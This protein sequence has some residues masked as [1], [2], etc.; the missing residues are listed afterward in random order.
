MSGPACSFY[1]NRV[2]DQV[3]GLGCLE[4]TR[5]LVREGKLGGR[6]RDTTIPRSVVPDLRQEVIQRVRNLLEDGYEHVGG[7]DWGNPRMPDM[8]SESERSRMARYYLHYEGPTY[9]D[10][11]MATQ[12]LERLGTALK[13]C[14]VILTG[15]YDTGS[16]RAMTAC[17]GTSV[18]EIALEKEPDHG[19][20]RLYS[21]EAGSR[22][23]ANVML[24]HQ[25]GAPALLLMMAVQHSGGSIE[26][27]GGDEII[28][29]L[30]GAF[31]TFTHDL[32]TYQQL[33]ELSDLLE[34]PRHVTPKEA[35]SRTTVGAMYF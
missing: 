28:D 34:L 13:E 25:Q 3:V 22:L 4:G 2:S 8:L 26:I 1:V 20:L 9:A 19:Q 17:L 33:S 23:S 16:G 31:P 30:F 32:W 14:G 18:T 10:D 7:S 24:S 21:R 11:D 35:L 5:L 15:P 29:P 12:M 27:S 6:F